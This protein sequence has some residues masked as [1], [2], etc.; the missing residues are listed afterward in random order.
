MS[1]PQ[2]V[3]SLLQLGNDDSEGP[4][5][6]FQGFKRLRRGRQQE[7]PDFDDDT[8]MKEL[9]AS[10]KNTIQQKVPAAPWSTPFDPFLHILLP[11]SR[12]CLLSPLPPLSPCIRT[13]ILRH[14]V[15]N[16]AFDSICTNIIFLYFWLF[17]F[18][19]VS[20]SKAT[21]RSPSLGNLLFG[22][23]AASALTLLSSSFL[24]LAGTF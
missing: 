8:F 10:S 17:H 11:S 19:L 15:I 16:R 24:R 7:E 21:R 3:P 6:V 5:H 13:P 4:Q 22:M 1:P 14:L 20:A 18:E 9:P 23:N 12:P 2:D